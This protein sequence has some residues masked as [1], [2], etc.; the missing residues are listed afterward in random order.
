VSLVEASR[1]PEINAGTTASA[2]EEA[3]PAE[4]A[5]QAE[6]PLSPA[7]FLGIAPQPPEAQVPVAPPEHTAMTLLKHLA[8]VSNPSA[9]EQALKVSRDALLNA[10]SGGHEPDVRIAI[11]HGL[12]GRID[13]AYHGLIAAHL[14]AIRTEATDSGH[15]DLAQE[16]TRLL[17]QFEPYPE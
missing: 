4:I 15:D 17:Q 7:Q 8:V 13:V 6:A 9:P 16:A 12:L 3:A 14:E 10:L 2:T 11:V 5:G 1:P